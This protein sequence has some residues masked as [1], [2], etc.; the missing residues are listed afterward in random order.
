VIVNQRSFF[1][2]TTLVLPVIIFKKN[3]QIEVIGGKSGCC[4]LKNWQ[5][6]EAD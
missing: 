4:F 1:P 5:S 6:L 2:I 3:N